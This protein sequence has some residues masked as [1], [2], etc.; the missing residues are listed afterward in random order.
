[1][2]KISG[3]VSGSVHVGGGISTRAG[4]KGF[5]GKSKGEAPVYT[6]EYEV[7]PKVYEETVLPTKDKRL[8][9]DV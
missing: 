9:E 2:E 4:L 8:T 5:V 7:T 6:G 1:M 3:K